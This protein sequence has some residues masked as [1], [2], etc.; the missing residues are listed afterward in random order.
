MVCGIGGF[1]DKRR[2]GA[3]SGCR[4]SSAN[5]LDTKL[6]RGTWSGSASSKQFS[7]KDEW[8]PNGRAQYLLLALLIFVR[9]VVVAFA[10]L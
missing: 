3:R 2:P 10:T 5:G 1:G 8:Q 7:G 9:M 6:N 4:Q